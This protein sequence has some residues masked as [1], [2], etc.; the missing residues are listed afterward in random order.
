M[1]ECWWQAVL[2]SSR[3]AIYPA[4]RGIAGLVTGHVVGDE[5][6]PLAPNDR[7]NGPVSELQMTV[8]S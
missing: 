3:R 2:K 6:Y 7:I 4:C 1:P 8:Q 5:L